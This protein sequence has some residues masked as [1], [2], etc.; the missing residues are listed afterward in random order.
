MLKNLC[1]LSFA[2]LYAFSFCAILLI[3]TPNLCEGVASME[4]TYEVITFDDSIP[5][6][7]FVNRIG[8]AEQ[9]WHDSLE[10]LMILSGETHIVMDG[11]AFTLKE[12]DVLAINSRQ[13]HETS[14][15]DSVLITLQI[16]TTRLVPGVDVPRIECNSAGQTESPRY[17]DVRRV[18]AELIRASTE[19]GEGFL[20]HGW[21]LLYELV[22][23]LS[24]NFASTDESEFAGQ[25]HIERI[26]SLAAIIAEQY[27]ENLTLSALAERVHLSPP[28]LSRYFEK[29]F[30]MT[31]MAYLTQVRLTHA[32]SQLLTTDE[33][34]DFIAESSGFANTNAFVQ[35]FKR[36]YDTL[37]SIYRRQN[38]HVQ[39][40]NK[41]TPSGYLELEHSN[42]LAV[43]RKYLETPAQQNVRISTVSRYV[44]FSANERGKPLRH[45]WKT[46]VCVARASEILME[47]TR[48]LLREVQQSIGYRFIKFHGLLSDDMRV[49][50]RNS[51]G[52]IVYSFVL[53]DK[54]MDFL[55]SIGLKPL[56]QLSFMPKVLAKE[57]A[58]TVFN[59]RVNEPESMDEWVQLVNATTV[60]L[61]E[62]YGLKEVESWPFCV[63]N[64]PDTPP[65]RMFGF[66]SNED[67]YA[68]YHATYSAVK[69]C[70]ATIQFGS[71]S[72]YY[73][74]QGN[75]VN[76]LDKFLPWSKDNGCVPDF[77]NVHF[78]ATSYRPEDEGSSDGDF[79]GPLSLSTDEGAFTRFV[80]HVNSLA[81]REFPQGVPIYLTEWNFTPSKL[82][83][84]GD[85]CFR[86]CYVVKN[87]L[88]NYDGL[89][90]FGF[91][92]LSD[93]MQET[94]LP[95]DM[96]HGGLGLVTT[97]GIKKAGYHAF[98]LLAR[99]TGDAISQ[100]DGWFATRDNDTIHILFYDYKHFSQLYAQGEL[101][102]M[103]FT[104]RYTSFLPEQEMDARLIISDFAAGTYL[105]EET[106]V[107]RRYGSAFDEWVN[108][109]AMPLQTDYELKSLNSRSMPFTRKYCMQAQD[110]NLE[111]S[112]LLELLEVRLITIKPYREPSG[113]EYSMRK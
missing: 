11:R 42:Y 5:I 80:E 89:D 77:L 24:V 16:D 9:H 33:T 86:S 92:S 17:D 15:A 57:P 6:K 63:W 58:R 37:P 28:Y 12:S 87:I 48:A 59:F 76:W 91:W 64:E 111:M 56:V 107:N 75:Y 55:L 96:F 13:L 65:D 7:C 105:V 26:S 62:R 10:L 95:Q 23:L 4:K 2:N 40:D 52:S 32:V 39:A 29:Y 61:I 44:V 27:K 19:R 113:V 82:D 35:A 112:V 100:G 45:T 88:E 110:G 81:V 66:D 18:I 54:V 36:T 102:D 84:L 51:E 79:L 83:L 93:F 101:F 109:G 98:Q 1:F 30:G 53:M 72:T 85:T 34:M 31:F 49:C 104:S 97:N 3:R 99:L 60:H 69:A 73:I 21:A 106:I 74:V 108:M 78:Y 67:F 38:S 94:P 41:D 22:H 50:Q 68:F 20:S 14:S 43:L 103:T 90:S 47:D 71:P 70:S 25:K 8:R 46:F